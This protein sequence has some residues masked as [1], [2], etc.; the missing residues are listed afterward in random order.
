MTPEEC[1]HWRKVARL[2]LALWK[3]GVPPATVHNIEMPEWQA[4]A[5][6]AG[7]RVPTQKSVDLLLATYTAIPGPRDGKTKDTS[8]EDPREAPSDPR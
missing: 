5:D 3:H 8:A 2:A 1:Y 7:V 6:L 4:V